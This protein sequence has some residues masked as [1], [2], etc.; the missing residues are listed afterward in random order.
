MTIEANRNVQRKFHLDIFKTVRVVYGMT[1]THKENRQFLYRQIY[2]S[3]YYATKNFIK[4]INENKN[5]CWD[6]V[7]IRCTKSLCCHKI[8]GQVETFL[9]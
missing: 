7:K 3:L 8:G 4:Q 5:Q 6:R 1:D 9:S 2:E